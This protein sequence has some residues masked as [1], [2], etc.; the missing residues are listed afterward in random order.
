MEQMP[1]DF[2]FTSGG[3]SFTL[4]G[5]LPHAFKVSLAAEGSAPDLT[6]ELQHKGRSHGRCK[7]LR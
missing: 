5:T 7:H 3:R 1:T 6:L 4:F 2:P